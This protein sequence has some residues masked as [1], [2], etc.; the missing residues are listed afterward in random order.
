V[1]AL[2]LAGG[3]GKRLR[4]MT[5][6]RPKCLVTI[7]GYSI[8][9]LAV[10]ELNKAGLSDIVIATGYRA[11]MI[12]DCGLPTIFNPH[13]ATDNILGTFFASS[14]A[15][16]HGA[17]CCYSDIIFPAEAVKRVLADEHEIAIAVDP[18]WLPRYDGR[19]DHLPD[20]AELV[21]TRDGVLLDAGKG[22]QS[23][24]V[25]GEFMGL[26]KFS[27]QVAPAIH[28]YLES[29]VRQDPGLRTRYL[30]S[31]FTNLASRG[32]AIGAVLCDFC[33]HE[34]DTIQDLQRAEAAT[35]PG[36]LSRDPTHLS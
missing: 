36:R 4:P 3:V 13:F 25:A 31:L 6:D 35:T 5:T 18:N 29:A 24:G 22:L 1:K 2:I 17:I 12:E 32:H 10:D 20:E 33:W 7:R 28:Q 14:S 23:N 26:F 21:R 11:E 27:A 16:K 9:S 34:I 15:W 8:L 30:T 19:T